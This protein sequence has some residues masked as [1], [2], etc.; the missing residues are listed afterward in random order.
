MNCAWSVSAN[1]LIGNGSER[2]S[3]R[4]SMSSSK[5]LIGILNK[6]SLRVEEYIS[7]V[8][9]ANYPNF[10][11]FF[12]KVGKLPAKLR[13]LDKEKGRRL[14]AYHRVVKSIPGLVSL[15]DIGELALA[16]KLLNYL[17]EVLSN[18]ERSDTSR[19]LD[20]PSIRK[21]KRITGWVWQFLPRKGEKTT[22]YIWS[23]IKKVYEI[24]N[25]S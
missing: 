18:P 6:S 13:E 23:S 14:F 4:Q 17:I 2:V 5:K 20:L 8:N 25:S 24:Y 1:F 12:H 21:I 3:Y 11:E 7:F 22:V 9:P 16:E 19:K 10:E 15:E